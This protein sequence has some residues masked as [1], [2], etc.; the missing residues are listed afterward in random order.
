[1]AQPTFGNGQMQPSD[2]TSDFNVIS[3][4]IQQA[5]AR[6]RTTVLVKVVSVTNDGELS[7]VGFVDAQPL[8][9]ML[10]G[11]GQ[12]QQHGILLNLVYFRLQGGTNAIIIDPKVGDIGYT[13]IADRDI[14]AVKSSKAQANP[15]SFRR[16]DLADGIYCGGILN[17]VPEQ[18]VQMNS[19]GVKI[20]DK[21]GNSIAMTALGI[22]ITGTVIVN[23][24][25]ITG[26]ITGASG[27]TY[28]GNIATTGTV[29]GSE[30]SAGGIALTTHHHGG[31]QTGG[32]NTGPALP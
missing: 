29:T 15:G 4:I 7:P 10:D 19:E 12:A 30:V 8:V 9:N 2:T 31:V 14:S 22:V 25:E 11:A 26:T 13:V 18:Y 1:M 28:A 27:G 24:I 32:G 6:V 20:A 23:N 5:L 21:N 3:F 16:F 17:G